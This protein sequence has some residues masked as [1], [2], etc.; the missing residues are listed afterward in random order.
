MFLLLQF[1]YGLRILQGELPD[2]DNTGEIAMNKNLVGIISDTH[3][4]R[5]AIQKAVDTFKDAGVSL[6]LHGGDFVAPFTVREFAR[7]EVPFVGV[8]GNNDGEV[9]GL[10]TL[11]GKIGSI[12]KAP[13]ELEHNGVRF[14][15]MHEPYYLDEYLSRG[16]VDVIVYGHTHKIDIRDQ[17]PLVINPGEAC[18]WLTGHSTIVILDTAAMKPELI[19]LS[20]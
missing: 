10:T 5:R 12:H 20:L 7:L 11:Y 17:S 8:F 3:D 6:V 19:E 18:T 14:V 13:Y 4:D 16:G 15:L 2:F 1:R 9:A